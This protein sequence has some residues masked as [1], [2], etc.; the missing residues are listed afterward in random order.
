VILQPVNGNYPDRQPPLFGVLGARTISSIEK[1]VFFALVICGPVFLTVLEFDGLR[2][3]GL[4]EWMKF[5]APAIFLALIG[6]LIFFLP[7]LL[8]TLALAVP[9][10]KILIIRMPFTRHASCLAGGFISVPIPFVFG[11]NDIVSLVLFFMFGA[12][13][14]C[15]F[16]HFEM[17]TSAGINVK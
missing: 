8:Y 5:I 2:H 3:S 1:A 11:A 4:A 17:K 6:A 13:G 16:H 10:Y 14:G 12:V 7:A 9:L 15:L